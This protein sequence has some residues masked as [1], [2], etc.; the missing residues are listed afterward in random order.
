[1][2]HLFTET[3]I[4]LHTEPLGVSESVVAVNVM[5]CVVVLMPQLQCPILFPFGVSVSTNGT[6]SEVSNVVSWCC[7]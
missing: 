7:F 3:M 5:V 1:M 2:Q 6:A 4:G